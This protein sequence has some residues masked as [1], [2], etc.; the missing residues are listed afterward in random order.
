MQLLENLF[1]AVAISLGSDVEI[2]A[3]GLR[4]DVVRDLPLLSGKPPNMRRALIAQSKGD[5]GSFQQFADEVVRLG[6]RHPAPVTVE[7][8]DDG[9]GLGLGGAGGIDDEL[10]SSLQRQFAGSIVT[11]GFRF[12][13]EYLLHGRGQVSDIA[14]RLQI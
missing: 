10:Q 13:G 2:F 5:G 9:Q 4:R 8:D 14:G 11:A 3:S 1:E 12:G 7:K 6:S